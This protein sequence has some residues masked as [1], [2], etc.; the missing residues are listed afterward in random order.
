MLPASTIRGLLLFGLVGG[1]GAFVALNTRKLAGQSP[2]ARTRLIGGGL[3]G[4]IAGALLAFWL[5]HRIPETNGSPASLV[6][7]LVLWIVGGGLLFLGVASLVGALLAR[8][9]RSR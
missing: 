9:A 4:A 1:M 3:M 6:A 8:P 7:V 2:R 5:P